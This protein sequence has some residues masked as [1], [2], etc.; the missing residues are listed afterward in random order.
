MGSMA[1]SS[2][3]PTCSNRATFER[4][5]THFEVLLTEGMMA[6]CVPVDRLPILAPAE[7]HVLLVEWNATDEDYSRD[8][9]IHQLF[10]QPRP[11]ARRR[12]PPWSSTA[13]S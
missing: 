7:R 1:S 8:R 12:R 3:R 5:V 11:G 4:M 9:C 2:T 10:E 6:P 13:R